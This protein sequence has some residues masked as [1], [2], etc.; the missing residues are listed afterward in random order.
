MNVLVL[1]P[2]PD[3]AR[4]ADVLRAA[5]FEPLCYP[6]FRIEPVTWSPPVPAAFDALLLTSVNTLRFGGRGLELYRPMPCFAVG[7]ATAAAARAAGFADVR[8]GGGNI[9]AT[10]P[11][12]RASG[13]GRLL[14]PGGADRSAFDEGGFSVSAVPVYRAV[15]TGDTAGLA[16]LRPDAALV[17]SPR[18]GER[19]A[20]LMEAPERASIVVVAI[21]PAA[22]DACGDGWHGA[23]AAMAPREDSM[24]AALQKLVRTAE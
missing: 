4:T 9:A 19:L 1:R 20:A 8:T 7:E 2:A 12:I 6:L 10:L 24:I 16:A 14:H 5:G 22:L 17:H 13:F 15:P 3:N 21:S 18:A 11:A 23:A